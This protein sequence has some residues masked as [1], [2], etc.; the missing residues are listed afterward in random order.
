M[1]GTRTSDVFAPGPDGTVWRYPREVAAL[2]G[3]VTDGHNNPLR[4][5]NV[6]LLEK[7]IVVAETATY[8]NGLYELEVPR[9]SACGY[10]VRVTL[11]E[12][13]A[14]PPTFQIRY[15]A[16][17]LND[18]PVAY[19][20]T[21]VLGNPGA[22]A[23]LEMD[24]SFAD[25]GGLDTDP[26]I[27][28]DRL[29]DMANIY[30]RTKQAVD[31]ATD[32]LNVT[33]DEDLPVDVNTYSM[34]GTLYLPGR[35]SIFITAAFS[36][37]AYVE[38]NDPN[39]NDIGPMNAEWHEF[40]HHLMEDT[41]TIPRREVTS[42]NH[43]GYA[44]PSTRDSWSEG[45]AEFWTLVLKDHQGLRWPDIY[46]GFGS[47]EY[48]RAAW[49]VTPLGHSREEFAVASLLWDLYDSDADHFTKDVFFT[50]PG[51]PDIWAS[52]EITS[53]DH[54]DLTLAQMWDVIG[55]TKYTA[56][57]DVYDVYEA[58]R[59]AGYGQGDV[60]FDGDIDH[61][62]VLDLTDLDELFVLHGFFADTD[63]DY[64]DREGAAVGR[65]AYGARPDRR[66]QPRVP[67][68]N[69]R[70]DIRDL[71]GAPLPGGTLVVDV[72]FPDDSY[73]Y[74]YETILDHATGNLVYF[75]LPVYD[76]GLEVSE[77]LPLA[78]PENE[79]V[80]TATVHAEVAG[81]SSEEQFSFDHVAYWNAVVST[82]EDYAMA[83]TFSVDVHRV[84]LPLI[85]RGS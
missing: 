49:A 30:F 34:S 7:G 40:F 18:G 51:L 72:D 20:E 5:V 23:R 41:I 10:Q 76:H 42:T 17:S 11:K 28:E 21:Q 6:A 13:T 77:G 54:L 24:I 8:D 82:T 32:E 2:S 15:G 85:L 83:Y 33:L 14:T 79:S 1:W 84:Y 65:A 68:A 16:N 81:V 4:E 75:E 60:D 9:D 35:T 58:F 22:G 47:F 44:N 59:A 63:D 25:V 12:G 29:D 57:R 39:L 66:N 71:H 73:D 46:D 31:F 69:L 26:A 78:G 55:S 45:Y 80:V 37:S 62:G 19:A 56:L 52:S 53:D 27:P 64:H 3:K 43:G 50:P 74:T 70:I 67:G 48:N 61:D 38:R 36:Q